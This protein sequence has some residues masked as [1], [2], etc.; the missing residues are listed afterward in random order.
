MSYPLIFDASAETFTTQGY[1]V[2]TDAIKCFVR[3]Q[4]NGEYEL[5][6]DYPVDGAHAEYLV[7]RGIIVC[8]ANQDDM[9]QAFRIYDISEPLNGKVT[10]NARHISYDLSGIPVEPFESNTTVAGTLDSLRL[11]CQKPLKFTLT[12]D[13]TISGKFEVTEPSSLRSWFGGREGSLIDVFRGEWR[14][15]NYTCS[16]LTHRG[17]SRGVVIRYGKNL[18]EY[19]RIRNDESQYTGVWMYYQYTDNDQKK[20][21]I[22]GDIV[23][24]GTYDYDK[25]LCYDATNHFGYDTH[26]SKQQLNQYAQSYIEDNA[27]G[28]VRQSVAF[29]Y[30]QLGDAVEKVG[31]GDTVSVVHRGYTFSA[32]IKKT[33][34]NVLVDRYENVYIGDVQ[35]SISET[36]KSLTDTTNASVGRTIGGQID[37]YDEGGRLII[38]GD[39]NEFYVKGFLHTVG[40]DLELSK[41]L[42]ARAVSDGDTDFTFGKRKDGSTNGAWS[43]V[44]GKDNEAS[45]DFAMVGGGYQNTASGMYSAVPG[46]IG[47]VAVADKQMVFGSFNVIDTENQY[48]LIIGNGVSDSERSN[49]L[50]LTWGGVLRVNGEVPDIRYDDIAA[51][52]A[53]NQSVLY[54]YMQSQQSHH[55]FYKNFQY[56]SSAV[57]GTGAWKNYTIDSINIPAANFS[58]GLYMVNLE[59]SIMG[60]QD[61]QATIRWWMG[62]TWEP[63]QNRS[64]QTVPVKTGLVSTFNVSFIHEY[65][66]GAFAGFPQIYSSANFSP[67]DTRLSIVR[68]GTNGYQSF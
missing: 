6:M 15:D 23:S 62:N 7:T 30:V 14:Y 66:S 39:A 64:R 54:G 48:V 17:T 2:L 19:E 5:T 46:G 21:I 33:R 65:E 32:R 27:L 40:T 58:P 50:T 59:S 9:R 16:L 56:D 12:T 60:T 3:E 35:S 20:R 37:V 52:M 45:G 24:T 36:I 8:R 28:F 10:V 63:G 61:G 1:G 55:Q 41:I 47:C 11:H 13:K 34:W 68:L 57:I 26:P 18:T 49:L 31:L 43:F 44:A 51:W 67:R 4:L 38:H 22:L 25:I 29:D 42:S 53:N